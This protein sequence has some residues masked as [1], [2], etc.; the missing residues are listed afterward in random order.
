MVATTPDAV[1]A[2]ASAALTLSDAERAQVQQLVGET[3]EL[4]PLSP[5]QEGLYFESTYDTTQRDPYVGSTTIELARRLPAGVL[6]AALRGALARHAGLRAGFAQGGLERPVQFITGA[7]DVPISELDLSHLG[8]AEEAAELERLIAADAARRFDLAAPPLLRVT[9]ARLAGGRE[10]ILVTNHTLLLDGWS[11]TLFLDDVLARCA[12]P[13]RDDLGPAPQFREYLSWLA[14]QDREASVQAW[15]RSL[16]GLDEPTLLSRV[17]PARAGPPPER[18][19]HA[20]EPGASAAVH[21]M[22]RAHGLTLNTVLS[23]AWALVLSGLTGRDDIVFGSTVSGRPGELAGVEQMVGLFLNTVPVRVVLRPAEPVAE[24]LARVQLEQAALIP[25]HHAGL[26]DVQRAA[27]LGPLFDTLQVLR[28]TPTDEAARSHATEALGVLGIGSADSTHLPLTFTTE[29][30]EQLEFELTYRPDLFE[31]AEVRDIADRVVAVLA[32]IAADPGRAVGRIDAGHGERERERL[33][34]HAAAG[35]RPLPADTVAELL[36][37]RAA[38]IGGELALVC[39][40]ERLTYAELTARVNRL[41]RL[42]IARGAGPERVVALALPRSADM[43]VALFA[44]LQT[45]AAYLPLETELP[46]DRLALMLADAAPMFVLATTATAPE[47]ERSV[48]LLDDPRVIAALAACEPTVLRDAER[49]GF[50][51]GDDARLDHP[52]YVIYTSGSTGVP[53]GVVTPYRGLTNMQLNHREQIFDPVVAAAGGRRLRIAHTVSFAFDMS[54]EE[55]LWLVEGHEVHVADE[56]LR[57][58]AEALVRYGDRHAIDVVNVT[59]TYAQELLHQGLLD[60]HRPVL[61]LLGGEA[62]TDPVWE[63]LRDTDGVLGYNLYG[64][65]EYTIN[66]LG[67][68]TE[69]SRVPTVGR[70]IWNT[71]AYVLDSALRP[72]PDGVPGELYI[73]GVGLA[74]GYLGR[75]E[76]TAERFVADPFCPG[77][78]MYRSG[79]LVRRGPDGNLDFLGRTDDQVKIRGHRVEPGE[80]AA[81]LCDHGEVAQAAVVADETG[82]AG[83]KRLVSYVVADRVPDAVRAALAAEQIAEWQQVYDAEYTEIPTAIR[84]EDFAGWDSSYDGTPIAFEEMQE[85]RATTVERILALR[86]RRILEIGVGSGLLLGPLAAASEEYRGTDISAPVIA[87]L[88]AELA[89][90]P[91]LAGRV[92]LE[93]RPADDTAGLPRGWFDTV[94]I[95]SVAQYFPDVE[96]LLRVIAGALE[97]LSADG[98][99]FLGD[100]RDRRLLRCLRTAVALTGDGE[101]AAELRRAAERSERSERELLV[102][103][104]LFADLARFVPA[105]GACDVLLKRGR[106]HNEL[107]RHRYDVIVERAGGGGGGGAGRGAVRHHCG[108]RQRGAAGAVR[109]LGG[110]RRADRR[111]GRRARPAARHRH[112][113]CPAVRRAR[114]DARVGSRR[115]RRQCTRAAGRARGRRARGSARAG[116]SRAARGRLPPVAGAGRVRRRVRGPRHAAARPRARIRG[117]RR[118]RGPRHAAARLRAATRGRR[119]AR[120]SRHAATRL[121]TRARG[122][123]RARGLGHA[124]ARGR[125]PRRARTPTTRHP[126]APSRPCRP[127]LRDA[128]AARLPDYMVPAAFVVVDRLPLTANGKLDRG[129][130]PAAQAPR[131]GPRRA[132]STPHEQTLCE[133]FGEVLG[134]EEVGVD[135]DFFA[136]GGHSLLATRLV[137]RVRKALG[138]E[139]AIRD[140]FDAPTVVALAGRLGAGAPARPALV[141][142]ELRPERIPVSFAQRRLWLVD[143]LGDDPAAYNYALVLDI[144]DELDIEALRAAVGDVCARHE[145]LRT[146]LRADNG[147]PFQDIVVAADARVPFEVVQC[148]PERLPATVARA[149]AHPFELEREL[150]LRVTVASAGP[151]AHAVVLLMHHIVTDEWSDRPL[152]RDLRIAYDARLAGAAPRWAPLPVQYADYALWQAGLLGDPADPDSLHARQAEHWRG[153]LDGLPE[154]IALPADRPRPA[155]RRG[156][157]ATIERPLADRTLAA[158]RRVSADTGTSLFMLAHAAVAALLHRMGAGQDIPLGSPIAGRTDTAVDDLV[159]FFVNTIVVRTD[160]GGDPTFGELAGRVR[161]R[162]LDAIEHQDLPFEAVV[163]TLRPPRVRGRNPLFQAMVGHIDATGA[164]EGAL[165]LAGDV[166]LAPGAAAKFDLNIVFAETDGGLALNVEYATDRFDAATAER[167]TER[168]AGLLD[169]VA[170]DPSLRLGTI[171]VLLPHEHERV[172]DTAHHVPA[173]TLRSRIEA[174]V[175]ALPGAVAVVA[176]DATLTYAQLGEQADRLATLLRDA[177]AGPERIVGVAVPRSSA[178]MVALLGVLKCGAAYLPLD[179]DLPAPRIAA[180]LDDAGAGIVVTV[181]GS[182]GALPDG[183][184]QRIVLDDPATAARLAVATVAER[185]AGRLAGAPGVRHLHVGIDRAAEGRRS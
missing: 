106:A 66:T 110:R 64:P 120:A 131:S 124:A 122:R 135:E 52:A 74:R 164:Q 71:A 45:G 38:L 75:A 103:P 105:A 151:R 54:W 156:A 139:L 134:L 97:L 35:V 16:A 23:G 51:R 47:T 48:V 32:A 167:L 96:H 60:G 95:N 177:G 37:D 61:V 19:R 115:E 56:V 158:L 24:L 5:L 92:R 145:A 41:A 118:A 123:R 136:L 73:A 182:V 142:C 172:D 160:T 157:A 30:G 130:L 29:R 49:P 86:P 20:L 21:A 76:L 168:L 113:R 147:E 121:R 67:G 80:I 90:T 22:A 129:A 65:T 50:E 150:P 6:R 144:A 15:R 128:L 18:L 178:L 3:E 14:A 7:T 174:R 162:V 102:D 101:D 59:P 183:G 163:E 126:R 53:K 8:P 149:A 26:G 83:V 58:D 1:P 108:R 176:P 27:G 152:L 17:T 44:V 140:L 39:G 81:A 141:A 85:W 114:R 33:L 159:G 89:S 70:P 148:E 133:L 98:W 109:D 100:L 68:G 4:W 94:V 93:C 185:R 155:V 154:E 146:R 87:K 79:D 179:L 166:R 13:D 62:V 175:A 104:A 78:R 36:D 25:H 11:A 82:L 72:L 84:N 107:T 57:R 173:G 117:Q 125:P 111:P 169:Q 55:L 77:G 99:L 116:A 137:S 34:E 31:R 170:A 63:A 127:A 46:A 2:P 180:M 12:Q 112:P 138:A 153:A 132:P 171:D 161:G 184:A 9:V 40:D 143:Q 69:D 43:V 181:A 91:E 28:N 88:E 10:W 165:G 42:L 119:R